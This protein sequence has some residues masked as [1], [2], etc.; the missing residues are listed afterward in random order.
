MLDAD[1]PARVDLLDDRITNVTGF[2]T[3]LVV[4][5]QGSLVTSF[6][7]VPPADVLQPGEQA[8][9]LVYRL[10]IQKQPGTVAVPVTVRVH[11]PHGS[12][13]DAVDGDYTREG[14]NLLFDLDLRTDIYL[15]IEFR[16]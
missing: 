1:V 15:R 10:K 3:L 16:P 6:D 11:L 14:D 4:P 2:G 12:R 8:G 5:T 13:L 7:F 9:D